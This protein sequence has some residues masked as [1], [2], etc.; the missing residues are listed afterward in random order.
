M[1]E[2]P[3]F[4]AHSSG[5]CIPFDDNG[6]FCGPL[7]TGYNEVVLFNSITGVKTSDPMAYIGDLPPLSGD[8]EGATSELS[9]HERSI[10]TLKRRGYDIQRSQGQN[11]ILGLEDKDIDKLSH[12]LTQLSFSPANTNVRFQQNGIISIAWCSK[13]N[14]CLIVFYDNQGN[15]QQQRPTPSDPEFAFMLNIPYSA[16]RLGIM[17]GEQLLIKNLHTKYDHNGRLVWHQ[18]NIAAPSV[19]G[20]IKLLQTCITKT[21]NTM[22][23]D[24]SD[25]VKVELALI[26][27]DENSP[28]FFDANLQHMACK[29]K[30]SAT[31]DE[32]GNIS[33]LSVDDSVIYDSEKGFYDRPDKPVVYLLD[34][35]PEEPYTGYVIDQAWR[36]KLSAEGGD[37]SYK[38]VHSASEIKTPASGNEGMPD[39]LSHSVRDV[40][41]NRTL[42]Q[43]VADTADTLM[44]DTVSFETASSSYVTATGADSFISDTDS[45]MEYTGAFMTDTGSY[46]MD[47]SLSVMDAEV[48]IEQTG[49]CASI[50]RLFRKKE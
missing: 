40:I 44:T 50:C 49:C 28:P 37:E 41:V 3:G 31:I 9:I 15:E 45:L 1:N 21:P 17:C 7:F 43:H 32:Q 42:A 6:R 5:C 2:V 25:K 22:H 14:Q 27:D 30:G 35:I 36:F 23:I 46:V 39:D 20:F 26:R 24:D 4:S 11:D 19:S 16:R 13:S 29:A 18:D 10:N 12:L 48:E 8:Y 34:S 33:S 38:I 47:A